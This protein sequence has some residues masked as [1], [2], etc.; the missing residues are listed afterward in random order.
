[1]GLFESII[2]YP[3]Y[4]TG[5]DLLQLSLHLDQTI[6]INHKW[7]QSYIISYIETKKYP[8]PTRYFREDD[9][10]YLFCDAGSIKV[11]V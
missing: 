5:L 6:D 10:Y 4:Q 3:F 11:Q 1:M 2:F 9:P 7:R 8:V